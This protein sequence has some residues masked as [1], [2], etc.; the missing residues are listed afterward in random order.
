LFEKYRWR[1]R[2]LIFLADDET[3]ISENKQ[4]L[5]KALEGMLDRD[6]LILGIGKGGDLF[7][8]DEVDLNSVRQQLSISLKDNIILFGKDGTVKGT[9]EKH[10]NLDELFKLIDS[11]PMRKREMQKKSEKARTKMSY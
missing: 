8:E 10:V 7:I 2:L 9:W 1:N 5:I 6:L 3:E 4:I 11:M